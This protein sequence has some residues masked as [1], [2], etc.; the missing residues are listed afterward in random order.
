[1]SRVAP[2][3]DGRAPFA[4]RLLV[5]AGHRRGAV[6]LRARIV[7]AVPHRRRTVK[8]IEMTIRVC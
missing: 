7:L 4:A 2:S 5:P 8:T 1:L 3:T 6:M